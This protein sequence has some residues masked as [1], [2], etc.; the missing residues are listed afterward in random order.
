M[1][2]QKAIAIGKEKGKQEKR[3]KKMKKRTL[4]KNREKCSA[5]SKPLLKK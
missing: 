2:L 5:V 1:I 4:D 3:I